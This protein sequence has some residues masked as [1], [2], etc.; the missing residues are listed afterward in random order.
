MS[1]E[2]KK[3]A[4]TAPVPLDAELQVALDALRGADPGSARMSAELLP[5]IRAEVAAE[6]AA[7]DDLSRGGRFTV[8]QP[9]VPGLDGDPEIPLLICTPAGAPA[10]RPLLYSIHG[11]GFFCNDHRTGLDQ[12]LET[13]E[14]FGATLISVGYRLAPEHPYPAQVDDAYAG[15]LWA[16]AHAD[17]L[18]V[19]PDRVV[20]T[21][22]SAGG[23]LSAALALTVRDKGGPRLLGQLLMCPMLDDRNDSAS[24]VQMDDVDVWNRSYNGFGWDSLLGA[25][26][27]GADVPPYAAP[28]RATDLAGLPPAFLD[29]GSA[30]C[31]RDEVVAFA[32]R[33]WQA[34]GSAELHVWPGGFH[35]FDQEVPD[36][37]ISG[38]AVAA[39]HNWLERLLATG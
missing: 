21:G 27:G 12:L 22:V 1:H 13:A 19:D 28:A 35:V 24:A 5:A 37:R 8:S 29:V 15:L 39:R 33:I 18:G 38:A 17:E 14:R 31:L 34:G 3:T 20:V 6:V 23:G 16:A 7:L 2:P 10:S 30:E 32:G 4:P 25:L 36:A 11:G 9:S 26:R